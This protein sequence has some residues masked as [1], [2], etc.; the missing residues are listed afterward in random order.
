M[1]QAAHRCDVDDRPQRQS[2]PL[3]A[4]GVAAP[5]GAPV[6]RSDDSDR[7]ADPRE[8]K[9]GLPCLVRGT[10]S[11]GVAAAATI[12]IFDITTTAYIGKW[13]MDSQRERPGFDH[14]YSYTGH[15]RYVDPIFILDGKDTPA[16]GW[17]D[18]LSTDYAI[19]FI[20]RQRG[21]GKPWSLVVGFLAFREEP[22]CVLFHPHQGRDVETVR[23]LAGLV[24][25]YKV[26]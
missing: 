23:P 24:S 10:G 4:V 16:K 15:A 11:A 2:V 6:L 13:H 17:I 12:N 9:T 8:G 22:S 5:A 25:T 20:K 14:H 19:E 3:D 21:A 18:D 26:P 1:R 7:E